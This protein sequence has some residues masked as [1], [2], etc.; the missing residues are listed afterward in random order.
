MNEVLTVEREER[1]RALI[2][3]STILQQATSLA[4]GIKDAETFK[5][6]GSF[7]VQIKS[8]LKRWKD[9]RQDAIEKAHALHK[10]LIADRDNV[11]KPLD[12]AIKVLAPA[13]ERFEFEERERA[14]IERER[15]EREAKKAEEDRR[16]EMAAELE[17]SGKTEAADS[18]LEEPVIAPP[19]LIEESP[20]VDGLSF[21]DYYGFEVQ[22][23]MSLVIAVSRRE[24]PLMALLPNE[25]FLG[26]QARSMKDHFKFPGVKLVH[27]RRSRSQGSF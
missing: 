19:S 4:A 11:G 8:A 15:I 13:L 6:A 18:I 26:Q 5:V 25:K 23:L 22:D 16:L 20:K 12:D 21:Q 10:T 7:L 9:S 2:E 27:T 17:K 3:H 14:R 1:D 24:V